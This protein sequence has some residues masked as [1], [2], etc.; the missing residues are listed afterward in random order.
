LVG[1]VAIVLLAAACGSGSTTKASALDETCK[2]ETAALAR[3]GPIRNLGDASWA[4][5]SV[6][7][8]ERR[9]L[10]D[11]DATGKSRERLAARLRLSI[12]AAARSLRAIVGADAQQTM[13]P[14]RTG[15]VDARRSVT[16]A[17]VLLRSLCGGASR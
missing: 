5:R 14:V 4:L 7:G 11:V 17:A 12:G 9:A 2:R 16:D 8:L 6:L 1:A 3:V 10:A 15:V 13:T